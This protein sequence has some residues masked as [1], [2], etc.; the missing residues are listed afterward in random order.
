MNVG[1]AKISSSPPL[2]GQILREQG[3]VTQE[4]LDEALQIQAREWKY[5][6]QILCEM[7]HLRPADIEA[8][9]AIQESY[10]LR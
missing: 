9:L 7:G 3:K 6:G 8:A 2:F 4:I 5:L 10:G 1:R